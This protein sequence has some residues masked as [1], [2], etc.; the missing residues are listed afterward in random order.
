MTTY[1]LQYLST[2]R[3][4]AGGTLLFTLR[5]FIQLVSKIMFKQ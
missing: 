4:K 2:G 1:C 3:H 5:I